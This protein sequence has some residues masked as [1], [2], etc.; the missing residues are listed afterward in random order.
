MEEEVKQE[1][2]VQPDKTEM[3]ET[4]LT[5]DRENWV[6]KIKDIIDMIR[7]IDKI[8]EAQILMLSYRQTLVEQISSMQFSLYKKKATFEQH[9][10]LK[11]REYSM[12]YDLKLN[13]G[14]KEKFIRSDLTQITR[15][16]SIIES[17]I[18]Y[19]RECVRTL[20]NMGFAIQR[21]LVIHNNDMI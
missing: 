13:G 6:K 15:Q 1:T 12:S 17:H 18:D 19:Y 5:T 4:K 3:L 7:D 16:I 21:R 11:F 14:E 9:F 8:A 20:D 2:A 10:K